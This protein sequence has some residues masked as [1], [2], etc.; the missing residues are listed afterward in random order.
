MVFIDL[1]VFVWNF[2][3]VRGSD[4]GVFRGGVLFWV[5]LL[6]CIYKRNSF[7]VYR[8]IGVRLRGLYRMGVGREGEESNKLKFYFI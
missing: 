3:R 5:I 6:S 7:F 1:V 8:D 4:G 2:Y